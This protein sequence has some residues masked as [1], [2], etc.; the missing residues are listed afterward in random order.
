V[1][2]VGGRAGGAVHLSISGLQGGGLASL[3][4]PYPNPYRVTSQ[5]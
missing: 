2:G 4:F 3:G 5:R 1:K